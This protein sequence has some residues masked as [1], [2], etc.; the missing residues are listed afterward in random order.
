VGSEIEGGRGPV[1]LC[2]GGSD[3]ARWAI[4]HAARVLGDGEGI[5]L[6]VWESLGSAIL[7][8]VASGEG[9]LGRDVKGIAEDSSMS[10]MRASGSARERRPQRASRS[11]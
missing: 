10:S 3:T 6:T 1:L 8:H 11:L 5:V 2:Y 4:V 9:A 7:R